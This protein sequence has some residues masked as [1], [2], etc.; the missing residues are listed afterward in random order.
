MHQSFV[1]PAPPHGR[2]GW[3]GDSGAKV[4]GNDLMSSPAVSG[5]C[6]ACDI[7]QIYPCEIYSCKEQGYDSQHV[8]A[9]QG[10]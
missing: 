7:A 3:A 8:P 9:V 5:K 6:R 1:T 10:F 4:R 2:W